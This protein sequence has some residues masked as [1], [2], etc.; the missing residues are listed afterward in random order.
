TRAW[1]RADRNAENHEA[2]QQ[3]RSRTLTAYQDIDGTFVIRGRLT[4]EFGAVVRQALT[5][6]TD[7]LYAEGRVD[8]SGAYVPTTTQYQADALGIIAEAALYHD[9]DPGTSGARY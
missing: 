6:A 7:R 9:L 5:A 1:R 8:P 3:H 4:P 2:E